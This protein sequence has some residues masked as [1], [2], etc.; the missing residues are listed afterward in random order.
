MLVLLVIYSEL[1]SRTP[2]LR[3]QVAVNMSSQDN[4]WGFHNKTSA[5]G[6][7]VTVTEDEP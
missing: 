1:H 6:I 7:I 2:V 5:K 3:T 4:K